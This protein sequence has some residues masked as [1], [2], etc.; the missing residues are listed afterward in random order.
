MKSSSER[1]H[2]ESMN[3]IWEKVRQ[4]NPKYWIHMEDDWL[5]F[6]K[7]QYV[8]RALEAL[9]KYQDQNIHQ[10]VF[11]REYGL[12][13]SDVE[14]VNVK[15]LGTREEALVLHLTG[16][17]FKGV[18][19]AYWPHFSLQP[20]MCRASALLKLGNFTSPNQ[21]F[22]R[23]YAEKYNAAGFKTAFFDFI[24]S[25]HIG[26]QHWEKEGQ[27]A[28]SL[29]SVSQGTS[30]GQ[31]AQGN[32]QV[33][34]TA[35]NKEVLFK[36]SSEKSFD[37]FIN[38]LQSDLSP[39]RTAPVAL[40]CASSVPYIYFNTEQMTR[41]ESLKEL[42]TFFKIKRPL[43]VWDYSLE[44]IKILEKEGVHARHVPLQCPSWYTEKLKG[45]RSGKC[46]YDVGFCGWMSE[47]RNQILTKLKELGL[48]VNIVQGYGDYRDKELAKCRVLLNIHYSTSYN[49]FEQS[50][51]VPWMNLGVTIISEDSLDND[52]RIINVKYESL[53]ETTVS[54]LNSRE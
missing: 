1:G 47:R 13:M 19:C 40:Q 45:F 20:S 30:Q 15:Q 49:I 16:K 31:E 52:P 11:N 24:H 50:R 2:R 44:N 46:E 10:I 29:N 51:C 53:V 25:L 41:E 26:K 37:I 4:V 42:L 18:N 3:L 21:F 36:P 5:F 27:N 14:R 12:M 38:F 54:V 9:E 39:F 48:R 35:R 32:T 23:D 22:E 43:E 7:E 8:T 33:T 34:S 28:Y 17:D 6:K